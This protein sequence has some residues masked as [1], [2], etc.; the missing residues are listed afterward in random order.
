MKRKKNVT[1]WRVVL[2][3][4]RDAGVSLLRTMTPNQK[5]R[6]QFY[7]GHCRMGCIDKNQKPNFRFYV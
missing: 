6:P 1:A 5:S 3:I 2:S 4:L 7:Y